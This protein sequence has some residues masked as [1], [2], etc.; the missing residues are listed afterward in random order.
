MLTPSEIELFQRDGFAGPFDLPPALVDP[1]CTEGFLASVVE[2]LR[3]ELSRGA[4]PYSDRLRNQHLFSSS[5]C[6]LASEEGLLDRVG[7]ILGPDI[8]LWLGH[9][10]PRWP[11][12]QGHHWHIDADN[13]FIRGV[14]VSIALANNSEENGCLRLIPGSHNYRASLTAAERIG[15]IDRR[16]TETVL[17]YADRV[18][19]HHAP[20]RVLPMPI[21]RGQ[22]FLMADGMWHFVDV[23]RTAE[24]RTNVIARFARTDVA[25]RDYGYDESVMEPGPPLSCILVRG[26]DEFGINRL[27]E[28]PTGD[29]F[30]H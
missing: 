28:R 24:W 1:Y 5:L 15:L 3:S 10:A 16:R 8:L 17:A 19:P 12:E 6:R 30:R 18:A 9:V 2:H 27:V 22:Y 11:N 20:H 7:S 29:L 25:C 21:R 13:R 4:D 14:H 26:R 23:N